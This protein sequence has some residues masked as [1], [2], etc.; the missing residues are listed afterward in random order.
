[1]IKECNNETV[2]WKVWQE[3][4]RLRVYSGI[5]GE[6]GETTEI[7]LPPFRKA[8]TV[9]GRLAEQRREEGYSYLD[10]NA[11]YL[12]LIQ[13]EYEGET[14]DIE[15]KK[16]KVES[17]LDN[18]LERTGNGICRGWEEGENDDGRKSISIIGGVVD[19]YRASSTTIGELKKQNLWEGAKIAYRK[20]GV[21]TCIHPEGEEFTWI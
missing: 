16:K 3:N 18:C 13:Y 6:E 20:N 21:F 2:Y 1:M 9:M 17:L 12:F 8:N 19:P 11:L 7:K 14:S 15:V 10:T 5:V 4:R